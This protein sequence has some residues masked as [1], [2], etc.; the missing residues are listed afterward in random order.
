VDWARQNPEMRQLVELCYY[1]DP[2][3]AAALRFK[4][5][6]EWE[7]IR[8]LLPPRPGAKVLEIGAGRGIVS[9][10]FASEGC[11]VHAIEPDASDVIGS[12]AIR[13]L[14]ERTGQS[15]NIVETVGENLAFPDNHF[16]YVV[17]RGVLHHVSDLDQ[18]CR[19]AFRVLRPGGRFLAIKEHVAEN[20][21]ELA[22][23]LAAHPLNHL[24][25]GEHAY[26]L[27]A[28][29][30]SIRKAGFPRVSDFGPFDHP[31][32]S[33]PATTTASI[34]ESAEQALATRAPAWLAKRLAKSDLVLNAYR[35]WRTSRYREPGRLH[36]FLAQKPA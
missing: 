1:D 17:C 15:L 32:T 7:A 22:A 34:R 25:G 33:A 18:V 20:A 26:P 27:A 6:E 36:S 3:E 35:R 4:S 23:F 12:G 21:E 28:Y 16:D 14:C 8:D 11:E 10:A 29:L 13:S 24:Y 5:S 19:E 2:I 31:V 30:G 9:W